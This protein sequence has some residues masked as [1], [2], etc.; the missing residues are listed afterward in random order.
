MYCVTRFA[1][2]KKSKHRLRINVVKLDSVYRKTLLFLQVDKLHHRKYQIFY[3]S[4]T[5]K[6]MALK[7]S[8]LVLHN[9]FI[10]D[11]KSEWIWIM[12]ILLHFCNS[13]HFWI[14]TDCAT[15]VMGSACMMFK[16]SCGYFKVLHGTYW[17]LSI[18]PFVS[19]LVGGEQI[20]AIGQ[21]ICV[22]L[23]ISLED[24]QKELEHM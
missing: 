12:I 21:G 17:V 22:L 11:I 5:D 18:F 8:L 14:L 6:D 4:S 23:G 16:P 1:D 2:S 9:L 15:E 10:P 24:T 13:F 7:F 19:F 20:S 3:L